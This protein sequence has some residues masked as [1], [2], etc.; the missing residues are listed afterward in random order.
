MW[1]IY[2][3][4]SFSLKEEWNYVVCRQMDGTGELHLSEVRQ[5]KK[6]S[7]AHVFVIC[8]S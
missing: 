7:K 4:V 6:K 3:G 5:A 1:Y 2:N 8:G